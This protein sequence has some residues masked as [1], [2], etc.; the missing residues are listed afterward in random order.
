MQR[1]S[2]LDKDGK[3]ETFLVLEYF[4]WVFGFYAYN[5][6]SV[7]IDLEDKGNQPKCPF[8]L[9]GISYIFPIYL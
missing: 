5:R 1:T 3:E 4:S 2:R 7:F 8:H 9:V 6:L